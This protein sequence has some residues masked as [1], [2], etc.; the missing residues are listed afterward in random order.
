MHA[1]YF[2]NEMLKPI[3]YYSR[4]YTCTKPIFQLFMK[5]NLLLLLLLPVCSFAQLSGNYTVGSG[6]SSPFNTLQNAISN[7]NSVGVS[8]PVIFNLSSDVT[9]TAPIIINAFTGS[10]TTNT[11][12]IKPAATKTITITA[13]NL[14]NYT[15]IP[16]VIEFNGA[17][18]V[19]IDGSN[20]IGGTSRDLTINNNNTVSYVNQSV[21]WIASNGTTGSS[22][23]TIKNSILKDAVKNQPG[24]WCLGVYSGNNTLGGN[25]T[26]TI[27]AATAANS[28]TK[29]ENNLFVNARQAIFINS[30][31][32]TA[33]KSA[34]VTIKNNNIGSAIDAEKP[35]LA[36]N[37]INVSGFTI[38][39][40][41]INGILNNSTSDAYIN[42]MI[43]DNCNDYTIKQN[44]IV[45]FS[46]TSN[47]MIGSAIYL[48]GNSNINGSILENTIR[49]IRN[50]GGGIVR[51][52]DADM[53]ATVS[54]GLLIAN[55]F[56]SDV[57]S[58]GTTTNNGNGIFIRKGK[59]IRIYHN[60]VAMNGNQNNICA[61]L[62]L[63]DGTGYSIVNNIFTNTSNTGTPYGLYSSVPNTAFTTIDYNNYY[64]SNLGYLGG[65]KTTLAAWKTATG[66][67]ANSLNESPAFTSTTD[68]H[69]TSSNCTLD[70]KGTPIAAI[71]NDIDNESR[72][73]TSPDIG[74]DEFNSVKCCNATTWNGNAWSNGDPTIS[75]KA[76]I[77]GNYTTA[78]ADIITCELLVN[79][80]YT[81]T[82]TASHYVKVQNNVTVNGALI[83]ESNGSLVQVD[84]DAT[85][86]GNITVKRKTARMKLY[87][88][89]YWSAPVKGT[90]LYQLSPNTLGDKYFSFSP[91]I[92]NYV[93]STNGVATMMPG[94][95]YIVRAPQGWSATN[96]TEG[97]YEGSFTGVANTGDVPVT[98]QKTAAGSLNL[99]G[100]PYPSAIDIDTFLNEN[101][102]LVNGTIY[103][104]TH[105][106]AISSTIPGNAIYNY[107]SDDFA[108]YNLTGGV[109]TAT[110]AISGGIAPD[111]K[112]ASGQA[113]FVE[114]ATALAN[115]T[116]TAHFN[117]SMRLTG[118][119]NTFFRQVS[120]V[121]TVNTNKKH[122]VWL[123][124]SGE[125]GAYNEILVGYLSGATNDYDNLYDG[126]T[127]LAGNVLS[128]YSISGADNYA[129][130]GRA[131]P[132]E[133]Q[134]VVPLGYKTSI[135]GQFTISIENVDGL[136]QNK[137]VFL[138]DR[139][140]NTYH[141]LKIGA[142]T[143]S[144]AVGT[145]NDRFELRYAAQTLGTIDNNNSASAEVS[146]SNDQVT[147]KANEPIESVWIYDILGRH[148]FEK[149]TIGNNQYTAALLNNVQQIVIVKI[150]L[151]NGSF[152][153]RKLNVNY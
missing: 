122:R 36:M 111:G 75:V 115:G 146:S 72:S 68:L 103:L 126:K 141:D 88:Y 91:A 38:Q 9:V 12:T 114:A 5:K 128:F 47:H 50:S 55:N 62:Y 148:L 79:S 132:F 104:W 45:N 121:N 153:T 35:V 6:Q 61:A 134:D 25:S 33:L 82:I 32:S 13:N 21:I 77:N 85:S 4:K 86:T 113:F 145:F 8:G 98:I 16:A 29:I 94:V 131:L 108:K 66:K 3:S 17:S 41:T 83:I 136:L 139:T 101:K 95:G 28:N 71:T 40:N 124:L 59:D 96:N 37:M 18:N 137:Q 118:S 69:L 70:G 93:V 78:T 1:L 73:T 129:I 140:D 123:S 147:I 30:N 14:N 31:A 20:T 110:R 109:K 150:K 2:L 34:S 46:H 138:F 51:G 67:D 43:I 76:I 22:N 26:L 107:T 120:N 105:N 39:G 27:A 19:I 112:I 144:S 63:N 106:T 92:N 97:V 89:T 102:T 135:A 99:I 127:L 90:T 49:S 151:S 133:E 44:S 64:A 10:S 74:A 57:T 81:L 11:L 53:N 142:F 58:S 119:N 15:G 7:I 116:Y 152:I 80:G 87:D 125:Q 149:D 42:A 48:K 56:I 100:N 23:I 117:N 130:Q 60:S 52:I 65:A 143:F 24:S 84:D 54:S